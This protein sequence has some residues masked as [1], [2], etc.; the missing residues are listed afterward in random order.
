MNELVT[1]IDGEARTTTLL[2]AEGTNNQHKNVMELVRTSW[3]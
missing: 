3:S 1:M 2:I